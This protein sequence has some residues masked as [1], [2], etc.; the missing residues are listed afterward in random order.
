MIGVFDA[1]FLPKSGTCT[2]GLDKFFSL[3]AG[4]VRKGLE[5][6]VLGVVTTMSRRIFAAPVLPYSTEQKYSSHTITA[7][8]VR[9]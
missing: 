7:K 8:A 1:S 9:L 4:A 5:V 6:S 2:P 3:A